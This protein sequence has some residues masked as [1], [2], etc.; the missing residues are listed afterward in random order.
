MDLRRQLAEDKVTTQGFLDA[1]ADIISRGHPERRASM[2]E[3]LERTVENPRRNG[4]VTKGMLVTLMGL[5]PGDFQVTPA[6]QKLEIAT[7]ILEKLREA[8]PEGSGSDS[9]PAV[10]DIP[11]GWGGLVIPR[12]VIPPTPL[13]R[14]RRGLCRQLPKDE[15]LG[16]LLDEQEEVRRKKRAHD[17]PTLRYA[18]ENLQEMAEN[19]V[20][21]PPDVAERVVWLLYESTIKKVI[22]EISNE[23]N[24]NVIP[25]APVGSTR[26]RNRPK[27]PK[28]IVISATDSDSGD[29][30]SDSDLRSYAA[31]RPFAHKHFKGKGK[32]R[33]RRRTKKSKRKRKRKRNKKRRKASSSSGSSSTDSSSDEGEEPNGRRVSA[34]AYDATHLERLRE[35][36]EGYDEWVDEAR[37]ED[38]PEDQ[39]IEFIAKKFARA[40]TKFAH[41]KDGVKHTFSAKSHVD[42]ARNKTRVIYGYANEVAN[43]R[44]ER[45]EQ[46]SRAARRTEGASAAR[47]ARIKKKAGTFKRA[48][49]LE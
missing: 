39:A 10:D 12:D 25:T 47:K 21:L 44:L 23:V 40:G 1:G 28:A 18:R 24:T 29:S 5:V 22:Q 14:F 34:E 15:L 20:P 43:L 7:E 17:G 30:S 19:T 49:V 6:N 35:F 8:L 48:S 42:F 26:K 36:K 41:K 38:W 46:L 45:H 37:P 3:I 13:L 33:K 32:K 2:V 27:R 4:G 31:A 9:E 16:L 11:D